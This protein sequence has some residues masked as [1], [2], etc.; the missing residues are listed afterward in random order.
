MFDKCSDA[1]HAI[2]AAIMS[3]CPLSE[4]GVDDITLYTTI[5][6]ALVTSELVCGPFSQEEGITQ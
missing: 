4:F 5:L 6:K 3:Q 2:T 1:A